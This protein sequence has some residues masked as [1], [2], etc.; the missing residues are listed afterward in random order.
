MVT[1]KFGLC[2]TLFSMPLLAGETVYRCRD[3]RGRVLYQQSPCLSGSSEQVNVEVQSSAWLPVENAKKI[4]AKPIKKKKRKQ[5]FKGWKQRKKLEQKCAR[6]EKRLERIQSKLR[7]GY[8]ASQGNK[9]RRQREELED[10][11]YDNCP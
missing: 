8:K 1:L 2:L 6:V 11:H 10:F 7:A 9:L 5:S 4:L 3:D